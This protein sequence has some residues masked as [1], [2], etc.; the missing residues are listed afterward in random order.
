M[1]RVGY[2]QRS[3]GPF[4]SFDRGTSSWKTSQRS[5]TEGWETFSARFPPSGSMRNGA[6]TERPRL[7]HRTSGTGGSVSRG[8]LP[9][10]RTSD[11]NGPGRHGSG[12]LDLRTAVSLLP[13]PR[14][15]DG[16]NGGP[17]QRGRR[18]DEA[19][20]SAVQPGRFGK[21]AAA[22]ERW[23]ELT[24]HPAPDA[25]E[26]SPRG[27]ERLAPAFVEW[28]MGLRPGWV[29]DKPI[30][31]NAQLKALG[32]GVVPQQA[33]EALRGLLGRM[34]ESHPRSTG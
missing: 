34:N 19:M 3:K 15:T 29:T 14:A 13:T 7:E 23:E 32:N 33:A 12:G 20:P 27:G 16:T 31:R 9:T 18:G 24:R 10:P 30:K 8:L 11:T 4:A 17:N 21:Y 28:M 26:P 22:V 1:T 2:G 25:T 6:L 5:Q